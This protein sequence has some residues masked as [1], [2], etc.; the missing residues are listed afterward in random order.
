MIVLCSACDDWRRLTKCTFVRNVVVDQSLPGEKKQTT[1]RQNRARIMTGVESSSSFVTRRR[2]AESPLSVVAD[3]PHDIISLRK[4]TLHDVPRC[5]S[6]T[7]EVCV[8]RPP[9]RRH[10]HESTYPLP[11]H[12]IQCQDLMHHLPLILMRNTGIYNYLTSLS[13]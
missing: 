3:G 9:E 1:H 12:S 11:L 2:E 5:V 7:S 10:L 8:R 13:P 6:H 4:P